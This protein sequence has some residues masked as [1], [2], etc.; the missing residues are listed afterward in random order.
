VELHEQEQRIAIALGLDKGPLPNVGIEWLRKYFKYLAAN[1]AFPFEAQHTEE[2]GYYR[3]PAYS[4]VQVIALL[5]PDK[6]PG[7]DEYSGLICR[8]LKVE[9]EIEVPLVDLEVDE[10]HPNFQ[11]IEDYWYW[12]WNWRFDPR[13]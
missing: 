13:I 1:L 7:Q 9:Q 2:I 12:I 10:E 3:Q 4:Q 8:I 6:N 5:D 11:L